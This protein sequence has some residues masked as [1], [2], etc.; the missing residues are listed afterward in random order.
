MT[1]GCAYSEEF[2]EK[3]GGHQGSVL[4]PLLFAIFVDVFTENARRNVVNKLLYLDDLVL[5]RKTMEDLKKRL[6]N[7]REALESKFESQ[8]QK[9]KSDGKQIRRITVQ[10]QDRSMW[11]HCCA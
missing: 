1:V 5:I 6:W 7:W 2:K 9:N 11:S 10:K 3:V 8:Q 4:S